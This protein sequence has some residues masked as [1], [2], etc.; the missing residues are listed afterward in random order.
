M[1]LKRSTA[2]ASSAAEPTCAVIY[3][4]CEPFAIF[5][6]SGLNGLTI[7]STVIIELTVDKTHDHLPPQ[8]RG[9]LV[10]SKGNAAAR[11]RQ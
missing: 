1:L 7:A 9:K 10:W 11:L 4:Q 6:P 3:F 8:S 5:T 2:L